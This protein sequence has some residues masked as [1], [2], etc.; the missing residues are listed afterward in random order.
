VGRLVP[1]KGQ[2]LLVE[3]LAAL[4]EDWELD[5]VGDG[6]SRPALAA[7]VV[8]RGLGD[9]VR[10]WGPLGQDAVRTRYRAADAFCLP[11]FAEGVPVVLMEAM[12][13]RLPVVATRVAGIPELV[14]HGE[15]G[16][17]VA[18]GSATELVGALERLAGDGDLRARLGEAARSRVARDYDLARNVAA[19]RDVFVRYLEAPA[20]ASPA[21]VQSR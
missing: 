3:A 10:L 11:S 4:G 6:P 14:S 12:A 5:L 16:L 7:E 21:Q 8:R 1:V 13:M 20:A 18:P 17:L 2:A 15:T 19:L 9:R